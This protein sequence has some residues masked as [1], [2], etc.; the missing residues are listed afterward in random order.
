MHNA[1]LLGV[2]ELKSAW[3]AVVLTLRDGC[4]KGVSNGCQEGAEL[5]RSNHPYQNRTENLEKNTRGMLVTSD[6]M[7]ATGIMEA[8]EDYASFVENGTRRSKAYPFMGQAYIKC[9]AVALR[10]IEASIPLAQAILDR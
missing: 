9:E 8:T 10:E 7:S 2:S 1:E 6:S 5:A 3:N 4:K